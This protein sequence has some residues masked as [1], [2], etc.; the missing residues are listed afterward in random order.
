MTSQNNGN[1]QAYCEE[2]CFATLDTIFAQT[3]LISKDGRCGRKSFPTKKHMSTQSSIA[4]WN[5][6]HFSHQQYII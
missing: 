1:S 5:T 3:D 4:R 2:W 6:K